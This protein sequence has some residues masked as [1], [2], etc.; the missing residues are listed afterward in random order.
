MF[1]FRL[2]I[3]CICPNMFM[4][5]TCGEQGG[6]FQ[7]AQTPFITM[8]TWNKLGRNSYAPLWMQTRSSPSLCC[9]IVLNMFPVIL[10]WGNVYAAWPS[11]PKHFGS[12]LHQFQ[13]DW[14]LWSRAFYAYWFP[15]VHCRRRHFIR[16]WGTFLWHCV[17]QENTVCPYTLLN[18]CTVAIT[19]VQQK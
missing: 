1:P 5:S 3:R 15:T 12:K 18:P 4:L 19:S 16:A 9:S 11:S 8:K 7:R 13:Q 2:W 10:G 6:M 14:W 17:P